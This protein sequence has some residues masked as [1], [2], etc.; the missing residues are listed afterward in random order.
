MKSK[1]LYKWKL[2]Q[3]SLTNKLN[4]MKTYNYTYYGQAIQKSRFEKNVP[5]NWEDEYDALNGYSYGG[6]RAN[7]V[8]KDEE[9]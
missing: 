4:I 8:Q 1:E 5:K 2:T 6:Y 9:E 7:E 3:E